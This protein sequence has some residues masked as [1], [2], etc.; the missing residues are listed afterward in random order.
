VAHNYLHVAGFVPRGGLAVS[1]SLRFSVLLL[2]PSAAG[3][4]TVIW[5]EGE[6]G[7]GKSS[8]VTEALATASQPGWDVG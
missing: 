5:I 7:I 8:L 6:A 2:R 4:G 1:L 3:E